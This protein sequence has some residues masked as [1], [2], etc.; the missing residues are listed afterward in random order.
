MLSALAAAGVGAAGEQDRKACVTSAGVAAKEGSMGSERVRFR[1]ADG[2]ALRGNSFRAGSGSC[3]RRTAQPRRGVRGV[4]LPGREDRSR[5]R[6]HR[7]VRM[8]VRRLDARARQPGRMP[9]GWQPVTGV[10]GARGFSNRRSEM[11][12]RPEGLWPETLSLGVN[13]RIQLGTQTDWCRA[14]AA[15]D[16]AVL[17]DQLLWRRHLLVQWRRLISGVQ[18]KPGRT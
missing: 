6:L 5:H 2:G 9:P 15:R 7:R 3:P 18:A 4:R 14:A 1:T 13:A 12:S 8:A 11:G 16:S 10:P 17:G